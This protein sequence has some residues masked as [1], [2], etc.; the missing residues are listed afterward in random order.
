IPVIK[1]IAESAGR[2]KAS[3]KVSLG[4]AFIIATAILAGC[5]TLVSLDPEIKEVDL[6]KVKEPRELL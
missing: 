6:I 2:I 4:D 5:E 1:R 3:Y